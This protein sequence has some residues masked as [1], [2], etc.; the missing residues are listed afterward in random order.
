MMSMIDSN[1]V[2]MMDQNL[3][4]EINPNHEIILKL[5]ELRKTDM[6]LANILARQLLDNCLIIAGA[7]TD[8]RSYVNRINQLMLKILTDSQNGTS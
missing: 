6:K 2:G 1:N 7:V 5:N 4:L 8:P 3:T